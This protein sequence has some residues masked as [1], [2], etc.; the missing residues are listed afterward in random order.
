M[1]FLGT[2]RGSFGDDSAKVWKPAFEAGRRWRN[3]AAPIHSAMK[4]W[5]RATLADCVQH[6]SEAFPFLAARVAN[7]HIEL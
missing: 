7:L 5:S 3:P 4:P 2:V 1:A 6:Y